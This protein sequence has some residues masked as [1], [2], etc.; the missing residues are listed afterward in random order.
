MKRRAVLAAGS[1]LLAAT[2]FWGAYG[3]EPI[4]RLEEAFCQHLNA[5][6]LH[7]GLPILTRNTALET[8]ARRHALAMAQDGHATHATTQGLLPPDRARAAGYTGTVQAEALA[9]TYQD[10]VQ[11]LQA[12]LADPQTQAVVF[13]DHADEV[14]FSGAQIDDADA[15]IWWTLVVGQRAV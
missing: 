1:T 5:A 8:M 3:G 9:E 4:V 12:W 10:P 6:R 15:R 2:P 13:N 11:T 14:G 7:V